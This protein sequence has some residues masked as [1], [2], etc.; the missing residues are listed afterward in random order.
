[1]EEYR[2]VVRARD[3]DDDHLAL[4]LGDPRI[5]KH[6]CVVIGENIMI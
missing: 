4:R 2:A 5:A 3:S 1:M 6:Q